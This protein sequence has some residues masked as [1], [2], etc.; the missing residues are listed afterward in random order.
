MLY[1][2]GAGETINIAAKNLR[3]KNIKNIF[4]ANRTIE[5]AKLL[6]EKFLG[7]LILKRYA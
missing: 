7:K 2:I 4:I 6:L 3:K 5:N 1:L